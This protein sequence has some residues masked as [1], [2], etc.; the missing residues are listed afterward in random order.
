MN[1]FI[2][3]LHHFLHCFCLIIL[4]QSLT[5]LEEPTSSPSSCT[6]TNY[7]L[8]ITM[9]STLLKPSTSAFNKHSIRQLSTMT[10]KQ[11]HILIVGGAYSGLSTVQNLLSILNGKGCL[12]SPIPM[13]EPKTLP[14]L[15]P[16]VTILDER[17]GFC[18]STF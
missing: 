2:I 10:P 17:D 8:G 7:D 15:K 1:V 18:M 3:R 12:P 16:R 9:L 5:P 14:S 13:S 6:A 11:R 4:I